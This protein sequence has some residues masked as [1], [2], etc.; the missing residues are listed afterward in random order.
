LQETNTPA[1][2]GVTSARQN[3]KSIDISTWSLGRR[4]RR[5]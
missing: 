3:K 5:G 1:Y 2:F 4:K